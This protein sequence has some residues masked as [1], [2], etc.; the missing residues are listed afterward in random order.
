MPAW[1]GSFQWDW[2]AP[3][4]AARVSIGVVP[5][6]IVGGSGQ[7]AD[8][9]AYVAMGALPAGVASFQG[10]ARGPVVAVAIATVGMALSTFVGAVAP[11][12]E[13][14]LTRGG[15]AGRE[16]PRRGMAGDRAWMDRREEAW[17]KQPSNFV[18][19]DALVGMM[20]CDRCGAPMIAVS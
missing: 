5:A 7:H 6:L 18:A 12:I 16:W 19:A 10:E 17:C 13:R 20:R 3:W 8:W 14:H 11:K 1:I 4:R 9:A 15:L 2:L